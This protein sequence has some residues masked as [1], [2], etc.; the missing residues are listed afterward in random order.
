MVSRRPEESELP[1]PPSA[2]ETDD[3]G[4]VIESIIESILSRLRAAARLAQPGYCSSCGRPMEARAEG[5]ICQD[6]TDQSLLDI[7]R[8]MG[9]GEL[10]SDAYDADGY[11]TA[12]HEIWGILERRLRRKRP[13]DSIAD[14]YLVL[15]ELGLLERVAATT[16]G[17]GVVQLEIARLPALGRSY[18]VV[19]AAGDDPRLFIEGAGASLSSEQALARFWRAYPTAE[20]IAEERGDRVRIAL[21]TE[22]V[23]YLVAKLASYRP[24]LSHVGPNPYPDLG[25]R[26][27]DAWER[28]YLTSMAER[29]GAALD[30]AEEAEVLTLDLSGDEFTF[31]AY[32]AMY[33]RR[34]TLGDGAAS[35]EVP[36][37]MLGAMQLPPRQAV[38]HMTATRI[39]A[40]MRP[41]TPYVALLPQRWATRLLLPYLQA[42]EA[43]RAEI[44]WARGLLSA[45]R[46]ALD[47]AARLGPDEH[48][49]LRAPVGAILWLVGKAVDWV[50]TAP[51]D[52]AQDLAIGAL[53]AL[54][55]TVDRMLMTRLEERVAERGEP[56]SGSIDVWARWS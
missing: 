16:T 23:D 48:A 3:E 10:W 49:L 18:G 35:A 45:V 19:I 53:N 30:G 22:S 25:V 9:V 13:G 14:V 44:P 32:F 29:L 33:A 31:L 11:P 7:A 40:F 36:P 20:R 8:S 39:W 52:E 50:E 6:C 38:A 21:S 43:S 55:L 46:A 12:E 28:P 27:L 37:G 2:A 47:E 56:G 5:S 42:T 54:G 26:L 15:N 51:D 24:W 41:E 4:V 17:V 34:A 1:E